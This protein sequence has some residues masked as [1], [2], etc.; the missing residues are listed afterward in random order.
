M[1]VQICGQ[2]EEVLVFE[3]RASDVHMKE[4]LGEVQVE[5]R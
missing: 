5:V 2:V 1:A 4:V 3:S